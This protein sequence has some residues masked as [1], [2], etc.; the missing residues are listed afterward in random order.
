MTKTLKEQIRKDLERVHY[1]K[2]EFA[3]E[4]NLE[5]RS[6]IAT[7]SEEQYKEKYKFTNIQSEGVT[8][9]VEKS[10]LEGLTLNIK[11]ELLFKGVDYTVKDIVSN[12]YTVIIDLERYTND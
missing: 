6:F 8:I 4:I 11:D 12:N 3:E 1:N 5:G 2:N 10:K 7:V 9:S